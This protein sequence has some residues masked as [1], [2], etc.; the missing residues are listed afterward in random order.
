MKSGCHDTSQLH[1]LHPYLRQWN[2]LS[3]VMWCQLLV[4][5]I[6]DGAEGEIGQQTLQLGHIQVSHQPVGICSV[7]LGPGDLR[8][9]LAE[10][11]VAG[12]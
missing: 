11:E 5:L 7:E 2:Q 9:L 6:G 3:E 8:A 12:P 10:A 4:V 1:A